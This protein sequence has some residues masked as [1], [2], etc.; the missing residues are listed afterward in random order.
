[1]PADEAGHGARSFEEFPAYA[2]EDA[3]FERFHAVLRCFRDLEYAGRPV[4]T[5]RGW[6][7]QRYTAACPVNPTHRLVIEQIDGGARY[8]CIE[9]RRSPS[10][11][12]RLGAALERVIGLPKVDNASAR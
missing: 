9:C 5:L 6:R 11:F 8:E 1:M 7:V 2:R 10:R 12:A 3:E 4:L